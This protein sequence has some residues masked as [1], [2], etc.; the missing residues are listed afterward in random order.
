MR[1]SNHFKLIWSFVE[2]IQVIFW[3][4]Q[5]SIEPVCLSN[6]VVTL[7]NIYRNFNI[8]HTVSCIILLALTAICFWKIIWTSVMS[9]R[10]TCRI[11]FKV[12]FNLF[13][14]FDVVTVTMVC[15]CFKIKSILCDC[16]YVSQLTVAKQLS[17]N[18]PRYNLSSTEKLA[19]ETKTVF[20]H[21]AVLFLL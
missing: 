9:E 8:C 2:K 20:L 16:S 12:A 6:V 17:K 21:Q 4:K 10:L 13:L 18:S 19:I 15:A 7:L 3:G 5:N 1:T 14:A 11:A